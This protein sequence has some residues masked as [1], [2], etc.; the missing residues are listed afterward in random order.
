MGLARRDLQRALLTLLWVVGLCPQRVP[1]DEHTGS[2]GQSW[3][4]GPLGD[5]EPPGPIAGLVGFVLGCTVRLP[6]ALSWHTEVTKW[7]PWLCHR[8]PAWELP[9]Q[10]GHMQSF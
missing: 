7:P 6:F 5:R 1:R 3:L 9:Q 2:R 8:L 4:T 10:L